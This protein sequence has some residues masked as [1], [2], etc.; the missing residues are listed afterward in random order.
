MMKATSIYD[1]DHQ[2]IM[3]GRDPQK[4]GGIID[5]NQYMIKK[6]GRAMLLDP[7]GIE[8]FSPMLSAALQ[9]AKAPEITDLFASHQDPDIISSLGFWDKAI[10]DATLHA[11]WLWESFIR[12]YGCENITYNPIPDEG[13]IMN[14]NGLELQFIPAHYLHSSA[15][16]HVYD[17]KA[18]ILMSG[19]IGAALDKHQPESE[20]PIFVEDF[21]EH[22]K[23]SRYFH[24][25]WMPSESAKKE[26]IERVRRLDI[27]MMVPQHGK[28][29]KGEMIERFLNWFEHLEVG[30][31][32]NQERKMA[33]YESK[34]K[35][36][37]EEKAEVA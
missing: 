5:S 10:P 24:Q 9:Y 1:E 12:H 28:I 35:S 32:S 27:D 17:P 7:G 15:N 6:G 14:F 29:Y 33:V 19:D 34:L 4:V 20:Q 2:W 26:W 8:L 23:D 31:A 18:K 16:Y 21:D 36:V 30:I 3:F 13:M 37:V 22:I 11:P 25:R